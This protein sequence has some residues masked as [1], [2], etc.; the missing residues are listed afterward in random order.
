MSIITF[1][2]LNTIVQRTSMVS[3]TGRAL[4]SGAESLERVTLAIGGECGRLR[5]NGRSAAEKSLRQTSC[6]PGN[7]GL[8]QPKLGNVSEVCDA[9]G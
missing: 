6:G 9:L 5:S 8:R 4:M 2:L 7:C 1:G 3:G